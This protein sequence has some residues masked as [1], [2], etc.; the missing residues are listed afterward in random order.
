MGFVED[1]WNVYLLWK[2]LW[3]ETESKVVTIDLMISWGKWG[4][5][6]VVTITLSKF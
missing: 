4:A 3:L 2:S 5:I 1:E 6:G